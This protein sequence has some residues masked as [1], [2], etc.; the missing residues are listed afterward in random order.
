MNSDSGGQIVVSANTNFLFFAIYSPIRRTV[1][2]ENWLVK[3]L[4]YWGVYWWVKIKRAP[5]GACL[6]AYWRRGR[7]SQKIHPLIGKNRVF[8]SKVLRQSVAL[9]GHLFGRGEL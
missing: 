3:H 5:K 6:L 8:H 2:Q 4:K 1:N 9:Y 7:D